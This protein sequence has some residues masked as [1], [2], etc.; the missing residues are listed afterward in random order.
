M[1]R[2]QTPPRKR[3]DLR[4]KFRTGLATVLLATLVGPSPLRAAVTHEDL[5]EEIRIENSEVALRVDKASGRVTSLLHHGRELLSD[6]GAYMQY[7]ASGPEEPKAAP[8][9]LRVV[10]AGPEMV[11]VAHVSRRKGFETEMHYVV[12]EGEPG[13]Y[14]YIVIRNDPSNPPGERNLEQVN[15]CVRANPEIFRFATIGPEKSG[16]LPTPQQM[17]EGEMVM[18]ATYQLKDGTVDAKYDW[19]LEETGERVFGLMG[20]D[21]GMFIVKDSGEALNSAPVGRELSVHQTTSTPVLLRHFVGGH[22]GRGNIKLGEADGQW[23]KLA[24][25]W[26]VFIAEGPTHE[27]MWAKARARAEEAAREWPY[28]WLKSPLYPL[29]RGKVSGRLKISDGTPAAGSLV[30]LGP[31]PTKRDP[32]WQQSGKGYFFWSQVK[33]DGSFVIDKVRAGQYSLWALN[34]ELFGEYRRDGVAVEENK[35]TELGELSWEPEK[36]GKVL[37]QIGQ[38]DRTASEYRHGDDYRQWGLWLKY[39]R[40]FPNDVDFVIGRSEE[41]KDWNYVQPAVEMPDGK[42]RLPT[43]KIRFSMEE[44]VKGSATLRIGV[45][46]VSAHAGEETG[47]ERWAGFHVGLNGEE[48]GA[49]QFPHDSGST[50]SGNRGRYHEVVIPF[51][52]ARLSAG[53]NVVTLTLDSNEPTG[54]KHNFPYCGVMYD[55]IRM[56]LK[57]PR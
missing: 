6:K 10:S 54:I 25:P 12:R 9:E 1:K 26:E 20:E 50:R 57:E 21:I 41:R 46:G 7:Y 51:E 49:Y 32:D 11:D 42:W 19:S 55:S 37:W 38:P 23:A 24:G 18:D 3:H 39:P 56:E 53:E 43:W 29:E 30:F 40:E 27:A 52:A 16:Y 48:L 14:N 31:T 33:D 45:A 34:N 4:R 15:L 2:P 22:Y 36:A 17:K 13:F 5:G 28:P 47:V 44:A 35:T 8:P